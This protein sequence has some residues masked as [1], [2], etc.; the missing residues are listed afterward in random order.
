[1]PFGNQSWNGNLE[2]FEN[3]ENLENIFIENNVC[4]HKIGDFVRVSKLT[5]SCQTFQVQ[6]AGRKF[7]WTGLFPCSMFCLLIAVAA[8]KIDK[9]YVCFDGPET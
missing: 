4:G 3:L 6:M 1:M 7:L 8:P 2:I 9:L 5:V